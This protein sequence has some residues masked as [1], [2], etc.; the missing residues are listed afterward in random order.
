MGEAM[1][2]SMGSQE[3]F[4]QFVDTAFQPDIKH[5]NFPYAFAFRYIDG[6]A[7]QFVLPDHSVDLLNELLLYRSCWGGV[8]IDFL[9]CQLPAKTGV[10]WKL[11]AGNRLTSFHVVSP[12]PPES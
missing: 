9:F 6:V 10:G 12:E 8:L 5:L 7:G 4:V 11:V 1:A 2:L 3:C